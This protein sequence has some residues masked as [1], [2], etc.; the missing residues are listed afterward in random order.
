MSEATFKQLQEDIQYDRTCCEDLEPT[1][2]EFYDQQYDERMD[3]PESKED[4][5]DQ[6]AFKKRQLFVSS[7]VLGDQSTVSKLQSRFI[8]LRRNILGREAKPW[9]LIKAKSKFFFSGIIAILGLNKNFSINR[10]SYGHIVNQGGGDDD[11]VDEV[12]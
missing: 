7:S 5:L 11:H 12:Q 10:W 4:L 3:I 6:Q 2:D 8:V 9:N 1:L